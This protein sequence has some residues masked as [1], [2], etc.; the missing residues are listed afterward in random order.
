MSPPAFLD[1]TGH[2]NN[3]VTCV[4]KIVIKWP[5][6]SI[7]RSFISCQTV[8]IKCHKHMRELFL[9]EISTRVLMVFL[10]R[11]FLL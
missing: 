9:F 4:K 2:C 5:V 6:S 10:G 7:W 8:N 11:W 3:N 1:V